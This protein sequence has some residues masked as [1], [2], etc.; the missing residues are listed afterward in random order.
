MNKNIE[1]DFSVIQTLRK[2]TNWQLVLRKLRL[3]KALTEKATMSPTHLVWTC[4]S[5]E[6][7]SEKRLSMQILRHKGSV[8]HSM[9][10]IIYI[11]IDRDNILLF[12]SLIVN[13]IF[14]I[15]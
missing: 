2:K 6:Y 4:I 12:N 3:K 1:K 10:P 9:N 13:C 8:I 14:A 5:Y 7:I 11:E 15:R